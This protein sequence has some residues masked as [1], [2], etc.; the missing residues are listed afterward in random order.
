MAATGYLSSAYANLA[1]L[2]KSCNWETFRTILK[3][4]TRPLVQINL[5]PKFLNPILKEK[6]VMEDKV[7][8]DKLKQVL[9]L[10]KRNTALKKEPRNNV[11]RL[12]AALVYIRLKKRYLNEGTQ[13][14]TAEKFDIKPNAL[15]TTI[16]ETKIFGWERQ[17]TT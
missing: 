13:A 12:L 9:L 1:A 17:A 6:L 15:S 10:Q 5:P 7:Y 2:A 11:T 8:R 3:A 4:S 14:E 16:V